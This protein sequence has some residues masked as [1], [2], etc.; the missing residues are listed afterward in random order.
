MTDSEVCPV[1]GLPKELC[2]CETL[3]K[4]TVKIKVYVEKKR[5]GKTVTVIEGIDDK[6]TDVKA[7][8][9]KFKKKLAC[10]G[11]YKD[12]RIE[13]QGNHLHKIK[14]LLIEEGFNED[15]IEIG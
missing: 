9:K 5:F 3:S 8:L 4:E 15:S 14:K 7:L 6:L 10:G 13:L 11:T 12:K 2:I 1:C